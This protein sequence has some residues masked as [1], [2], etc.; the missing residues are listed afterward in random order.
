MEVHHLRNGASAVQLL[1]SLWE[2][3]QSL[4]D[5]RIPD[6]PAPTRASNFRDLTEANQELSDHIREAGEVETDIGDRFGLML[7][8]QRNRMA[9]PEAY[10]NAMRDLRER[11]VAR[12]E[13]RMRGGRVS[14]GVLESASKPFP[15]AYGD[16]AV[17]VLDAMSF[18]HG[19]GVG[20]LGSMSVRSQQ[21]AGD[22]DA[23]EIVNMKETREVALHMLAVRFKDIIKTLVG[24]KDV[25]VGD[26][27]AGE[28]SEWRVLPRGARI[29]NGTLVG[30]NV[31][32]SKGR[33]RAL[34]REGIITPN[35]E[36]NGLAVL[37]ETMT[38]VQ[39]LRA[40]Q[41]FKF[42]VVRWSVPAILRG[43][44]RLR[45]GR[46][47]TLEEAFSSPA[48]TKLDVIALVQRNRYTEFSLIYYFQNRGVLLN[49]DIEDIVVSLR[50]NILFYEA[51]GNRFKVMKRVF[52]L[53]KFLRD[54][55]TIERLTPVLNSDLGRIYH[56]SSDIGSLIDLLEMAKPPADIVKYEID[57]F[58][59]RLSNVYL[60]TD[61][62]R[63]EH[64]IFGEIQSM[65]K[66]PLGQ[67]IPKLTAMK[68]R[69]DA[70]LNTNTPR[71]RP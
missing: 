20:L 10:R 30:M 48:I 26:C 40:K 37:S 71:L 25:Y 50:E 5:P 27:K 53:A 46:T 38:P 21:Y 34:R 58:K 29:R 43:E 64:D 14:K 15:E 12:A 47:F 52:A 22:Y 1:E 44:T 49:P 11:L 41:Q 13:G 7:E 19:K 35:E 23:F 18:T 9:D 17:R 66:T 62:L 54:G 36:T 67:L 59:A 39:F 32:A 42:H 60:L 51:E 63:H 45:D 4:G 55:A 70:I 68:S 3:E 56:V 65:L 57:Q 61:Y 8:A 2:D 24:M 33:L 16:D 6:E 31:E 28:V 69:L